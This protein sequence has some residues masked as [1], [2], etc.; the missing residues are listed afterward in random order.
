MTTKEKYYAAA[1]P[2]LVEGGRQESL[3][4]TPKT[5]QIINAKFTKLS[6]PYRW[7]YNVLR[8]LDYFARA[9]AP[10]DSRLQDAIDLLREQRRAD[11]RWPVQQKYTGK[12]FFEMEPIG[13]PSR[14]NTLRALRVLRWWGG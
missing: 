14:W 4:R 5:G 2:E 13:G 10:Q 9:A 1:R 12:V 11:G 3:L 8:G 7:Q 6:L